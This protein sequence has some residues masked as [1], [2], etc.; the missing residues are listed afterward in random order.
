MKMDRR[1]LLV[2]GG[3]LG[4]AAVVAACGADS[5]GT[6]ENSPAAPGSTSAGPASPEAP[7]AS[8][9]NA[10]P[11]GE[12]L[13]PVDAVPVTGG[14]IYEGPKVEVTQPAEGDVKA[15]SAVCPH[16]GCLMSEVT[17]NVIVCPCHNSLFSAE[18]GS[19][20]SG[21]SP[22]AIPPVAITVADGN[23]ILA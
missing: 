22:A 11:S 12:V 8:S 2:T 7:A 16:Q 3:S 15:F 14:V 21:P 19:V 10:T 5:A 9:A 13:G 1:T 23:I 18:D 6:A 17:D 4:A 20:I